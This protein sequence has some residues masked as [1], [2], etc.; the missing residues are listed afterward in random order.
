LEYRFASVESY[1]AAFLTFVED[2]RRLDEEKRRSKNAPKIPITWTDRTNIWFHF[3]RDRFL[4]A[5]A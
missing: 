1:K 4:T 3:P 2:E 5:I